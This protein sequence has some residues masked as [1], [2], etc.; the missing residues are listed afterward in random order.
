M[1]MQGRIGRAG[2]AMADAGGRRSRLPGQGQQPGRAKTERAGD[3]VADTGRAELEGQQP[4]QRDPRRWQEPDG[5]P[6][7]SGG[8]GL[9]PPGPG[10]HAAWAATL[11]S[12]PDLAPAVGLSDCLA[13]AR[14]LAADPEGPVSAAAEPAV[15]PSCD[16][17]S[18]RGLV[19]GL[20]HRSRA[21]HPRQ[22]TSRVHSNPWRSP[23][24]TLWQQRMRGALSR[25]PMAS[26]PWIWRP[27]DG[28]EGPAQM[29]LFEGMLP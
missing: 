15:P 10:D 11:A 24:R 13:W 6:A 1:S 22:R 26:G 2:G 4:G 18:H 25:R 8:T 17:Q 29:T 16:G 21:Q 3:P 19:D 12:R 20:A 23:A 27:S 28:P 7:L 5:Y 9:H 14:R